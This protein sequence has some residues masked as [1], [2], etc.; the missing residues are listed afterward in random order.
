MTSNCEACGAE[1]VELREAPRTHYSQREAYL[2]E[3]CLQPCC[4]K[5]GFRA[6]CTCDAQ[7]D[8]ERDRRFGL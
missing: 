2:C 6:N 7:Y 1:N 4:C 3:E 5:G 8:Q